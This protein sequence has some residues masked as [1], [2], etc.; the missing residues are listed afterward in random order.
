MPACKVGIVLIGQTAHPMWRDYNP[1]P[2]GNR[3]QGPRRHG[4][5]DHSRIRAATK[6]R[7][8]PERM[9]ARKPVC[10]RRLGGNRSGEPQAGRYF[11][12]PQVT[13]VS[14]LAAATCRRRDCAMN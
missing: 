8:A 6:Q 13:A 7:A 2:P 10:L 1:V 14:L 4:R 12:K 11:A 3:R 9:V 5:L